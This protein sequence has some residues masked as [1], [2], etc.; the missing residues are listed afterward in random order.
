MNESDSLTGSE[1]Y[2]Q[3]PDAKPTLYQGV[4]EPWVRPS[5]AKRAVEERRQAKKESNW[6]RVKAKAKNPIENSLLKLMKEGE[7]IP[8][9]VGMSKENATKDLEKVNTQFM[10]GNPAPLNPVARRSTPQGQPSTMA[11][12]DQTESMGT[13][14]PNVGRMKEYEALSQSGNIAD[15]VVGGALQG[16]GA[17]GKA[18]KGAAK[19]GGQAGLGATKKVLG[20]FGGIGGGKPNTD[21]SGASPNP[22]SSTMNYY[23]RDTK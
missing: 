22:T 2:A 9:K 5:R 15:F 8:S 13:D 19:L 18:A 7:I 12:A 21:P 1:D 3:D 17:A 20:A 16:L 6:E 23:S 11:T 14:A 4:T 10:Q